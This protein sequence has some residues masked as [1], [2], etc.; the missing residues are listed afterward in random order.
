MG[1][2]AA[3][4]VGM[5]VEKSWSVVSGYDESIFEQ[6]RQRIDVRLLV[7]FDDEGKEY[8]GYDVRRCLN[9]HHLDVNPS[10]LVYQNGVHCLSCGWR[11]DAVELYHQEHP[12]LNRYQCAA[13]LLSTPTLQVTDVHA[14]RPAHIQKP[15]R[16]LEEEN[17]LSAHFAL[18]GDAQAFSDIQTFG[19]T[20]DAIRHF[21]LGWKQVLVPVELH[22][23]PDVDDV[24]WRERTRRDGSVQ[25][26]PY[27]WQ[28]RF[29]VPVYVRGVLKQVIYRR[30]L[31]TSV[32]PKTIVEY[33][34]GKWL[35]NVDALR[36]AEYAV[37]AS[38]WGDVITLWQWDVPAVCS[39]AGDGYFEEGWY[40]DVKRIPRVYSL[41]DA[42]NAGLQFRK[43]LEQN[44]PW[45][46][47]IELPY[48]C[49][50]KKD[51]RDYAA[52]G[53]SRSDLLALMQKADIAMQWRLLQK[54]R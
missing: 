19:F 43:R 40:S 26:N 35:Y 2:S 47:H 42:D 4:F 28:W 13:A 20:P 36:S 14:E 46:R 3:T 22:E 12:D 23:V 49:G 21:R 31:H 33:Q 8:N 11:A 7:P 39:I 50:T 5:N 1:I 15:L 16:K 10:M 54:G 52:D 34:A 51:V 18:V 48:T 17:A 45:V 6:V 37:V 9:P 41:V 27:Q 44:I 30:A 53:Y 32:G 29:S 38:G 25:C 24:V